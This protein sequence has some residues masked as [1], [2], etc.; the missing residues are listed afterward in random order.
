M[1]D[2]LVEKG[3]NSSV[4]PEVRLGR[5]EAITA[6]VERFAEGVAEIER[7]K[8]NLLDN[9]D[10]QGRLA[11]MLEAN[12]SESLERARELA[13]DSESLEV[14]QGEIRTLESD[15]A[16]HIDTLTTEKGQ[17]AQERQQFEQLR[18]DA[19]ET[20]NAMY[21][22]L[23]EFEER[24]KAL[25]HKQGE[26]EQGF[27]ELEEREKEL[28][29]RNASLEEQERLLEDAARGLAKE[30]TELAMS[31]A[32]RDVTAVD[33]ENIE[34]KAPAGKVCI[35]RPALQVFI[36]DNIGSVRSGL[37][38]VFD[39]YEIESKTVTGLRE[40]VQEVSKVDLEQHYPVAI[41]GSGADVEAELLNIETFVSKLPGVP[42]VFGTEMGLTTV[43]LKAMKAGAAAVVDK[44]QEALADSLAAEAMVRRYIDSAANISRNIYVRFVSGLE[45]MGCLE[46]S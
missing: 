29:L 16:A 41:Y 13:Q 40:L 42:L 35:S 3:S 25:A 38:Q 33:L 27:N 30:R 26:L 14:R 36:V 12:A 31:R 46:K 32:K 5:E 6:L 18:E 10:G 1:A 44:P 4:D 2:D 21:Q 45:S 17:L 11:R 24:E 22:R 43:R 19:I 20:S 34:T 8:E 9:L 15:L 39:D 7:L 37:K 28:G 23:A